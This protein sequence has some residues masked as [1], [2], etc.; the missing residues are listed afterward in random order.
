MRMQLRPDPV[1]C[2]LVAMVLV[3]VAYFVWPTPWR[4]WVVSY[5]HVNKLGHHTHSYVHYRVNRMTGEEQWG[6]GGM[7]GM[8]N[9]HT[10][11]VAK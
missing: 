9:W 10:K 2:A 4:G 8:V 7:L 3:P 1:L 5:T 11:T 6:Y